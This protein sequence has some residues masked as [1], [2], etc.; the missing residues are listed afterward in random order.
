MR[1]YATIA[2]IAFCFFV[3]VFG[4]GA[5]VALLIEGDAVRGGLLIVAGGVVIHA[6]K[7]WLVE[8]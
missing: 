4:T 7:Q 5:G 2:C 1:T 3:G 8:L 6:L